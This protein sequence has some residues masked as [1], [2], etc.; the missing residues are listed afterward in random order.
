MS[1]KKWITKK[2]IEEIL[3]MYSVRTNEFRTLTEKRLLYKS[4]F[5]KG[6]YLEILEE[7]LTGRDIVEHTGR[8]LV[9]HSKWCGQRTY[10]DIWERDKEGNLQF[11]FRNL[12]DEPVSD[13]E[14]IRD[15]QKENEQLKEAG[16]NLKEQL[17]KVN[18]NKTIS[19]NAA[20]L[21]ELLDTAISERNHYKELYQNLKNEIDKKRENVGRKKRG[22]SSA[23]RE[24]LEAVQNI[25]NND[26]ENKEPWKTIGI[27]RATFFRY[28][29]LIQ[30]EK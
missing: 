1:R 30:D 4:N 8:I 28:K 6:Y 24:V 9:V 2:E 15:L 17:S 20:K 14:F 27:G 18:E 22:E 23:S 3:K 7:T 26:P 10:T 21:R 19:T 29:K 11:C 5:A 13:A 12:L 16:R 25:L